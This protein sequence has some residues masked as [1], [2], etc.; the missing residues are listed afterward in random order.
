MIANGMK[1]IETQ[2]FTQYEFQDQVPSH[3][4]SQSFA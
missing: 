4:E 2:I 1:D 3:K